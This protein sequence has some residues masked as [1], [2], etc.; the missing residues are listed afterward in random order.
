MYAFHLDIPQG[1]RNIN[2]DLHGIV[3]TPNDFGGRW[4]PATSWP[5]TGTAISCTSATSTT[6]QY[7]VR[8][9]IIL[10]PGWDYASAL[11]EEPDRRPGRFRRGHARNAGRLADQQRVSTSSTSRRGP[12]TAR[13]RISTSLPTPEDLNIEDKDDRRYK[14][15]TPEAMAFYGGRHWNVY[16]AELTLSDGSGSRASSITSRATT[17][18]TTVS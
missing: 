14:R 12:A 6:R 15:L 16:H 4:R 11:P 8:A 10:P 17:A 2:V 18:P 5:A 13:P 3:R 1:V 7:Y 9:S